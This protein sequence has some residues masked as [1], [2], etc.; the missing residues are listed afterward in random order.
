M[1][2]DHCASST[3]NIYY[4]NNKRSLPWTPEKKVNTSKL[5]DPTDISGMHI[6]LAGVFHG[7]N[8]KGFDGSLKVIH[9]RI[10]CL[11]HLVLSS[12]TK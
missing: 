4:S 8:P 7:V 10:G 5:T 3:T 2:L 6:A 9:F 12:A 11:K 1:V